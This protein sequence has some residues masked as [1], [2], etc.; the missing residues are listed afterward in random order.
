ML[1]QEKENRQGAL[2]AEIKQAV[3]KLYELLTEWDGC[4]YEDIYDDMTG[5][6]AEWAA[7]LEGDAGSFDGEEQA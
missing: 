7:R 6:T 5:Y 4:G 2:E 1:D 3:S